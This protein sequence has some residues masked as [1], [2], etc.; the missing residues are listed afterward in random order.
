MTT[1]NRKLFAWEFS[2]EVVSLTNTFHQDAFLMASY[3]PQSEFV[4]KPS[5]EVLHSVSLDAY[6]LTDRPELVTPFSFNLKF[7][8]QGFNQA[9]IRIHP[10]GKAEGVLLTFAQ[11]QPL[12]LINDERNAFA[13][14]SEMMK[15]LEAQIKGQVQLFMFIKTMLAENASADLVREL[16]AE[17]RKLQRETEKAVERIKKEYRDLYAAEISRKKETLVTIQGPIKKMLEKIKNDETAMNQHV[18]YLSKVDTLLNKVKWQKD[19]A[20]FFF[21]GNAAMTREIAQFFREAPEALIM[22]DFELTSQLASL[23][24]QG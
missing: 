21:S 2:E 22:F 6:E 19:L 23:Q 1:W 3:Q 17:V 15:F 14:R 24:A 11:K 16:L 18:H 7:P 10:V 13:G 12:L 9:G 5:I 4:I 20:K 8:S